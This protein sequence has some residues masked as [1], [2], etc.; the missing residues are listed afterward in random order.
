MFMPPSREHV[1]FAVSFPHGSEADVVKEVDQ[2]GGEPASP[3]YDHHRD[4][5]PEKGICCQNL[6]LMTLIYRDRLMNGP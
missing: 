1:L 3:E 2:V 5:E 6:D 4:A